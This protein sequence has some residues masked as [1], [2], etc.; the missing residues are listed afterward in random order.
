MLHRTARQ[1][2]GPAASLAATSSALGVWM[3]AGYFPSQVRPV[4]A[5]RKI[6]IP[7][8]IIHGSQDRFIPPSDGQALFDAIP[9]SNKHLRFVP[10]GEHGN[11]LARGSHPLYAEICRFFIASIEAKRI[12]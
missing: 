6:S 12:T 3:R 1:A 9:H 2:A 10:D 11:V 5:A 8:M 7:A 4:E